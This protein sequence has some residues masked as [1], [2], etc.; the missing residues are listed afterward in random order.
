M[1]FLLFA[2]FNKLS[3]F[4]GF[5][6]LIV[7]ALSYQLFTDNLGYFT[8]SL[9]LENLYGPKLSKVVRVGLWH[10]LLP[11]HT[12]KKIISLAW[13]GITIISYSHSIAPCLVRLATMVVYTMFFLAFGFVWAL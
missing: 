8:Q 4:Y 9:G 2:R 12:F 5:A 1:I 13:V 10:G 3:P 7:I 6:I 11:G